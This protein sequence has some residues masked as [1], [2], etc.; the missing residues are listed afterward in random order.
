LTLQELI[1]EAAGY[2]YKDI[3]L[4]IF[5][6]GKCWSVKLSGIEPLGFGKKIFL[7]LKKGVVEDE[8]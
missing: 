1:D 3:E 4:H 6:S 5:D 2:D 7:D 8:G